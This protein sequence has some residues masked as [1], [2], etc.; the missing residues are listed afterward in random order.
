M[1][2]MEG[3]AKVQAAKAAEAKS[4][5]TDKPRYRR[6]YALGHHVVAPAILKKYRFTTD[7]F[8][9]LPDGGPY[10]VMANHLT[11]VDLW[12]LMRAF[13]PHM[14]FVAGEHLLR[15]KA[16]PKLAWAQNPIFEFKGSVATSVVR[17]I[18]RRVKA[19]GN[20]MIFPEGSRSFNGRTVPLPESAAKLVKMAG[21]G[22]VTYHIEGGYFVAPRWA[23]TARVGHMAGRVVHALTAAEVAAM[24][25]AELLELIN[26][27]LYEDAY[28]TQRR[29]EDKYVGERLAEGLEN[30]LI[31]CS[32]CGA[33]DTMRTEDDR[34]VCETCGQEGVFGED[35]FL[36]GEGLR[37]DSV[38]DWG[39]WSESRLEEIIAAANGGEGAEPVFRDDGV[40]L[41]TVTEDHQRIDAGCGELRGYRDRLEFEAGGET[42]TFAF[43]DI[44]AM[45]MLYYGKTLLFTHAGIHCGLTGESFHALKYHKLYECRNR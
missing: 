22:L 7:I 43:R 35:G 20:V 39:A 4:G 31:C 26:T 10:I 34:F 27:D 44:P 12:M 8:E 23:Y 45:D 29:R 2:G 25:K 3:E 30:Y 40:T 6:I 38:Y 37:F 28:E 16:G 21:C 24:G 1:A 14:W 11:E 5:S 32:A 17:E 13:K 41:Y 15:S 42:R 19:G 9:G 18:L 33:V 36:H